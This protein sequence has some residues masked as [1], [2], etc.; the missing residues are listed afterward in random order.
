MSLLFLTPSSHL[1]CALLVI[2]VTTGRSVWWL[3]G[4][5]S[6]QTPVLEPISTWR[7]SMSVSHTV[8]INLFINKHMNTQARHAQTRIH[9]TTEK[10]VCEIPDRNCFNSGLRFFLFSFALRTIA[11]FFFLRECV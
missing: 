1:H 5:M 4:S 2:G 7:S 6:S 10:C 9:T 3:Q 11:T 8:S